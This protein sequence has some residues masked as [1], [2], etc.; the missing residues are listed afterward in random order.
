M[1]DK[2]KIQCSCG[3]EN[4]I[5]LIDGV[6]CYDVERH[7]NGEPCNGRCFNCSAVLIDEVIFPPA[8]P[9]PEIPTDD[10]ADDVESSMAMKR[11]ELL[12]CAA[13]MGLDVP[14]NATK[15]EILELIEQAD[16][17]DP[18]ADDSGDEDPDAD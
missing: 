17:D 18:D 4:Q 10:G 15:A 8:E 1:E 3:Q 6:W 2:A 14:K 9:E 11:A 16:E 5:V 12:A 13:D 7:G